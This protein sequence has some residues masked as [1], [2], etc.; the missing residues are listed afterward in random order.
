MPGIVEQTES[1]ERVQAS[2]KTAGNQVEMKIVPE[3]A[4]RSVESSTPSPVPASSSCMASGL[5]GTSDS[6]IWLCLAPP[7]LH[8]LSCMSYLSVAWPIGW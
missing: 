4:S 3:E 5:S 6:G 1:Q 2:L 8:T 7:S